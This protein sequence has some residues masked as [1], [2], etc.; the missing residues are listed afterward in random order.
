MHPFMI[1]WSDKSDFVPY[2]ISD[3]PGT[4]FLPEEHKHSLNSIKSK[5]QELIVTQHTKMN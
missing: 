1:S 5:L 4:S 2:N 3:K